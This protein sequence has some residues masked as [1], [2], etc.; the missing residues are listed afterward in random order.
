MSDPMNKEHFIRYL[1]IYGSDFTRWP[2]HI[3]MQQAKEL[4]ANNADLHRLY[5]KER[6]VDRHLDCLNYHEKPGRDLKAGALAEICSIS[7]QS[8][9]NDNYH[10]ALGYGMSMIALLIFYLVMPALIDLSPHPHNATIDAFIDELYAMT[11]IQ[12]LD[13]AIFFDDPS[14]PEQT[15]EIDIFLDEILPTHENQNSPDIWEM[16][17]DEPNRQT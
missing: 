7:N 2:D 12:K 13:P 17:A 5:V 1:T 14:D 4:L 11:D 6:E 8:T 9:A 10:L 15:D 3:D 16:F